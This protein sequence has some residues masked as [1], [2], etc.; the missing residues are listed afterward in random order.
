MNL[1]L[2]F[3]GLCTLIASLVLVFSVYA[4]KPALLLLTHPL[5]ER[6]HALPD[7]SLRDAEVRLNVATITA[8]L[9]F[10]LENL[11]HFGELRILYQSFQISRGEAIGGLDQP[12][13]EIFFIL[14]RLVGELVLVY[15]KDLFSLVLVRKAAIH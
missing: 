12:V 9:L 11:T 7:V 3:D 1:F 13:E 10:V 6:F 14:R 15:L 8:G 4:E 2:L 5:H